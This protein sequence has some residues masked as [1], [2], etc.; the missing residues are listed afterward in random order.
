ME[1]NHLKY[2][3]EVALAENISQAAKTLYITQPAL[4]VTIKRMEAE[5]GYA[6]FVRKGNK[7]QLTEAGRCFLSYVNS[8]FSLLDEGIKKGREL[9]NQADNVLRVASGFGVMRDMTDDYLAQSPELKIELDCYP[10]EEIIARLTGGQADVGLILGKARDIRLEERVIMTGK[11]YLCVNME[12][13]LAAKEI[14]YMDDL[15]GQLIFCSNI[16]NTHETVSRI[17]RKAGV[18]INLLTLDEKDVLFSAA[19][20]GL[21]GVFCMPMLSVERSV[22][23][24]ERGLSFIPIADCSEIGEVVLLRPKNNYYTEDQENYLRYIEQRFAL[25]EQMLWADWTQRGLA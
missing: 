3:R 18:N 23:M 7:I 12:H 17:M 24:R 5:L 20:K 25:N 8:I 22:N 13:P 19:E 6:L 16:A 10:T 15:E 9:A 1:L 4:S 2:F 21:G 14:L 11:F